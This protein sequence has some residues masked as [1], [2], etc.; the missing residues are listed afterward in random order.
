MTWLR[1][2]AVLDT[3]VL[4]L[5]PQSGCA[6]DFSLVGVWDLRSTVAPSRLVIRDAGEGYI[7]DQVETMPFTYQL[8]LSKDPLWFDLQFEDTTM[9]GWKTL[10]RCEG[11]ADGPVLK[12][13]LRPEDGMR[14]EWPRDDAS[15]PLGVSVLRLW[16]VEPGDS[17]P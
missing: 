6:E 1:M 11:S 12:W 10:L 13:V 15:A 3:V 5:G 9:V 14:P 2:L 8:D 17:V 4:S 7:R 16:G